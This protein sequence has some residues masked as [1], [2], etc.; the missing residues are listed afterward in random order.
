MAGEHVTLQEEKARYEDLVGEI[1][2]SKELEMTIPYELAPF[3][4]HISANQFYKAV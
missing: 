4:A 1:R 3:N 2:T